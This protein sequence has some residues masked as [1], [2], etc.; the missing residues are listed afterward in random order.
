MQALQ[1]GL[2]LRYRRQGLRSLTTAK[3][4]HQH[5]Q[6]IHLR[7]RQQMFRE[8][9]ERQRILQFIGQQIIGNLVAATQFLTRQR[10][11]TQLQP[12]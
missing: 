3:P 8:R 11:Q 12:A 1:I 7:Q 10:T 5:R 9:F 4:G 2:I 6:G